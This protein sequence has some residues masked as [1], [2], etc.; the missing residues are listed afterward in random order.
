MTGAADELAFFLAMGI[1]WLGLGLYTL[2]LLRLQR[3]ARR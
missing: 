1:V 3:R 2:H